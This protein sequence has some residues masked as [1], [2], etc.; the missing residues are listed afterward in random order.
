MQIMISHHGINIKRIASKPFLAN[1]YVHDFYSFGDFR[2]MGLISS[3]IEIGKMDMEVFR[4]KRKEFRH[5]NK[6]ALQE[7]LYGYPGTIQIDSIGLMNG[8]VTFTVHAEEANDPG[9]IS[10]NEINAKIYKVTNDTVYK[11]ES[12]F[13][14]IKADALLMG[15]GK[16]T[17]SLKGRLYRQR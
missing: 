13:L 8:N 7:M 3:Y 4:D 9:S 17:I 12:A 16:M 10:F 14:E 2:T 5:L 6:P 11:T 1:I 15:K